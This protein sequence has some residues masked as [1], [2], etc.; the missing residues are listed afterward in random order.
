M[1]T[2]GHLVYFTFW[3]KLESIKYHLGI[4]I[5]YLAGMVI[6]SISIYIQRIYSLL[7]QNKTK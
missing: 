2:F 3:W 6:K 7:T 5:I 1:E 4:I